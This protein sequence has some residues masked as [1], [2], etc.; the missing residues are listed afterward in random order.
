MDGMMFIS[1]YILNHI[2]MSENDKHLEE[3]PEKV[4]R[5]QKFKEEEQRKPNVVEHVKETL[6]ISSVQQTIL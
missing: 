3:F 4:A 2:Y 5:K 6:I 1:C